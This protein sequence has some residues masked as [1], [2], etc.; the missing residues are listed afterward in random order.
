M[1]IAAATATGEAVL[2]ADDFDD[3]VAGQWCLNA[4][5]A[6]ETNDYQVA[7]GYDYGH[8]TFALT[9]PRTGRVVT[10]TV[11]PAP[12]SKNGTTRGVRVTVNKNDNIAEEAGVNLYLANRIFSGNY[13]LRCDV[14]INYVG[15][16]G[17]G[18]GSTEYALF[19][20]NHQ[21]TQPNWWAGSP[22]G[23][24]VWFAV[25][26]D[27]GSARDYCAYEYDGAQSSELIGDDAGLFAADE[28]DAFFQE[29][30]PSGIF[31]TPG[32]IGKRW[33]QVEVSQRDG[34]V[35]WK[36]DGHVV[37]ERAL[38]GGPG[39]GAIMIGAMDIFDSIAN[40]R[41]D[42]W[43]LF[44]NIRVVNLDAAAPLATV[45]L[46]VTDPE[47]SE[48][49]SD[50]GSFTVRRAGGDLSQPLAV[51]YFLTGTALPGID[52]VGG[53]LQTVTIPANAEAAEVVIQPLDDTL[54]EPT[55]TVIATL[56]AGEGY[57]MRDSVSGTVL[58]HDDGDPLRVSVLPGNPRGFEWLHELPAS[59]VISRLGSLEEDLA[60][61]FTLGGTAIAGFDY[62]AVPNPVTIPA[63]AASV[64]V[65]V[66]PRDNPVFD[67]PRT[68]T[69]SLSPDPAYLVEAPAAATISLEDDEPAPGRVLLAEDFEADEPP[70]WGERQ[71]AAEEGLEYRV[72]FSH[73]YV[74]DG[75]VPAP[76][77]TDG[78]GRGLKLSLV[79][80]PDNTNGPAAINVYPDLVL[81]GEFAVRFDM[82]LGFDS[83]DSSLQRYA[84]AGLRHSGSRT[85]GYALPGGDGLWFAVG[86]GDNSYLAMQ[87]EP[88]QSPAILEAQTAAPFVDYFPS[89]PA[90]VPG[91]AV[92]QWV[93]GELAQTATE[94][95]LKLSGI[96]VFRLPRLA[97]PEE[98]RLML[99]LADTGYD[100]SSPAPFVLF[101]NLRVVDLRG[102]PLQRL[103]ISSIAVADQRV[104][105]RFPQDPGVPGAP[106]L[107]TADS[108]TGSYRVVEGQQCQDL[109][110]GWGRIDAPQRGG[111]SFYRL[112]R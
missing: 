76:G 29:R 101:D 16:P 102:V 82:Y 8:L 70:A 22:T 96:P 91:V 108:I 50:T 94:I 92:G 23:D 32:A 104:W 60:V 38:R 57:E 95:S 36:L 58:L 97:V 83:P 62:E 10:N 4:G 30:F 71:T 63:G 64:V 55:E 112:R 75:L 5:A 68:V 33:V 105:V 89:P 21:G 109:G 12:H 40:P 87:G 46:E 52:Y 6:S 93:R 45:R 106:I 54:G 3:G 26:G 80:G 73:D 47:A 44:D 67:G 111:M 88:D 103:R 17:G 48:P 74:A 2:F 107:E 31:E 66:V 37:A 72:A 25:D 7:L 77:S 34:Y 20:I 86:L 90:A 11:P 9:D 49:G 59:F 51:N 85:N 43:F 42:N 84:L 100:P 13:A 56:T 81:A 65:S 61:A 78:A 69:L 35:V 99:G 53:T 15:G 110:G 28:G 1:S 14:W 24:G 19:G 18:S 41:Y 79:R 98:G 27:G 39:T